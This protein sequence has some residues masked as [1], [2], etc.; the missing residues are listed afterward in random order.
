MGLAGAALIYADGILTPAI[1]VLSA[2]EGLSVSAPA[3]AHWTVPLAVVI[4]IGLFSIQKFGTGQVGKLFGPVVLL[5]FGTE[6]VGG[7]LVSLS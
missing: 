7:R 3:L 2:V 4:L 1:S 5:W 6:S